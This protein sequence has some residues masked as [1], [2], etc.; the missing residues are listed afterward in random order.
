MWLLTQETTTRHSHNKTIV[1]L[2]PLVF[3]NSLPTSWTQTGL[4]PTPKSGL[5]PEISLSVRTL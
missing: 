3:S 4:V 2:S 1:F 5:L